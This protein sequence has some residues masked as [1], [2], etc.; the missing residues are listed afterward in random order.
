MPKSSLRHTPRRAAGRA[1]P[2]ALRGSAR[3]FG[4]RR[5]LPRDWAAIVTTTVGALALATMTMVML[6]AEV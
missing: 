4:E 1:H 5:P 2:T 3:G 6:V